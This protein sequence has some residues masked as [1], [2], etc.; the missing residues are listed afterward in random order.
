VYEF[1]VYHLM[2]IERPADFPLEIVQ[3]G[4]ACRA[5]P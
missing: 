2:E 3:V 5:G 1:S 4:P